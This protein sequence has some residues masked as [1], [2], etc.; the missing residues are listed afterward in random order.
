MIYVA[1]VLLQHDR[2][3]QP[4]E[5]RPKTESPALQRGLGAIASSLNYIGGTIGN[6]LEVGLSVKLFKQDVV[7]A[8]FC[9]LVSQICL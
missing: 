6:A 4:S 1:N 7:D 5:N 8:P 9:H 2:T 3:Y